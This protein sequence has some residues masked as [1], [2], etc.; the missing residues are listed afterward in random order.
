M[1]ALGGLSSAIADSSTRFVTCWRL[2]RTDGQVFTFTTCDRDLTIGGEVYLARTG[3]DR[4]AVNTVSDMGVGTMDVLGLLDPDPPNGTPRT[5]EI[6]TPGDCRNGL[7]DFAE[8]SVFLAKWDDPEAGQIILLRG[9]LGEVTTDDTGRFRAELRSLTQRINVTVGELYSPEC[10]ASLGDSRCKFD[11]S[12]VTATGTVGAQSTR[13]LIRFTD[14]TAAAGYYDGGVLTMTSGKNAGTKREVISWSGPSSTGA[15]LKLFL[16]FGQDLAEGDTF[17]V[18]PGCDRQLSTCR[19]R[20]NNL[21]NY[22][23]E[24]C[25]PGSDKMSQYGVHA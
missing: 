14:L 21:L 24:P 15:E 18:T 8:V 16:P 25:V 13:S 7:F 2:A 19:D 5:T 22:R 6:I 1:R 10:R 12:T 3:I 20:F 9:W 17:T 4:T 11:L 23:G